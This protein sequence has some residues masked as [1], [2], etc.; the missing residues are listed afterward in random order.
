MK[1][2]TGKTVSVEADLNRDVETVMRQLE[3]KTGIPK[4]HQHLVS[5]GKESPEGQQNAE[6]L[7]HIC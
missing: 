2:W 6:R 4:D 5:K 7:W 1:T 3:T